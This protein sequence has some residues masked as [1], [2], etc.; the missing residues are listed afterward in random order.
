MIKDWGL[1]IWYPNQTDVRNIPHS[2][3]GEDSLLSYAL[4]KASK[5]VVDNNRNGGSKDG[6]NRR[7]RFGCGQNQPT[8]YTGLE[9]NRWTER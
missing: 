9:Q 4:D 6:V 8:S 1:A 5:L 7:I 3:A 2:T